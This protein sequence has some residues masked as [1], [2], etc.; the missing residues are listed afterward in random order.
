MSK[1]NPTPKSI[2]ELWKE[3]DTIR[4]EI[5]TN[6]LKHPL[7]FFSILTTEGLPP[8]KA[9]EYLKNLFKSDKK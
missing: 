9:K 8:G 2:S 5:L 4:Q 3:S 7:E 6:P 1:E